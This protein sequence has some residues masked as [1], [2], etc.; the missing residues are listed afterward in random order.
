MKSSDLEDKA[1]RIL[2]LHAKSE[3]HE[4]YP[5]LTESQ[6]RARASKEYPWNPTVLDSTNNFTHR[7]DRRRKPTSEQD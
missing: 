4:E 6:I 7:R 2:D 3:A 1:N 5:I